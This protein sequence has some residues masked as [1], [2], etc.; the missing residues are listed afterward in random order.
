MYIYSSLEICIQRLVQNQSLHS[1]RSRD[2][3]SCNVLL[4][5][6]THGCPS[7]GRTTKFYIHP[8]CANTECR[9]EDQPGLLD[10]RDRW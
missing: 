1:G 3:L 7:V 4:S 6:P 10:D 5:T 8:F 2:K 9:L